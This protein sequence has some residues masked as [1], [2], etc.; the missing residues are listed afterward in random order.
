MHVGR[1]Q[2]REDGAPSLPWSIHRIDHAEYPLARMKTGTPVRLDKRT[3]IL[4]NRR[5]ARRERLPPVSSWGPQQ[6]TATALLDLLPNEE[7]HAIL[8]ADIAN[9][10]LFNGQIQST[11]TL[12]PVGRDQTGHLSRQRPPSLVHRTE[13]ED[14][15][16]MTSTASPRPCRWRRSS[17]PAPIPACAMPRFIAGLCHR[18]RLLRPHTDD[19]HRESKVVPGSSLPDRSTAPRATRRPADR[20]RGRHQRSPACGGGERL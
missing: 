17:M 14:T 5:A 8:R 2:W 6:A 4:R 7:A 1:H 9:S 11:G 15:N 16:E 20:V 13:G 3:Y 12:L 19:T 18:V 10:P